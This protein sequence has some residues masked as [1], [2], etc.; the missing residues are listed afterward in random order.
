MVA[1]VPGR[2]PASRP[3]PAEPGWRLAFDPGTTAAAMRAEL[4]RIQTSRAA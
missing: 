3:K 4:A 1:S 2:D